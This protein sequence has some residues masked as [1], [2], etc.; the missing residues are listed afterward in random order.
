MGSQLVSWL[1]FATLCFAAENAVTIPPLVSPIAGLR[2]ADVRDTF[3]ETR[4]GHPHEA[5]DIIESRG[6]PVRAVASGEIR[7]LFSS[8]AGGITIYEFDNSGKLCYYYAHL[9]QYSTG[10]HEGQ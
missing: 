2:A 3:N 10:L 1:L 6:T 8:K 9:D 5:T 7:K 4:N